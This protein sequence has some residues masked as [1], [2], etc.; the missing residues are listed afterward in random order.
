MATTPTL[1]NLPLEMRHHMYSYLLPMTANI[2]MVRDDMDGPL[3]HN[4]FRVCRNISSEAFNYYYSTNTFVLDLTEPTYAPNRFHSGTISLLKYIRPIQTLQLVI[5]DSC[6]LDTD[7][8]AL[9][10]YA[11]EQ[12]DWFLRTLQE[13]NKNDKGLWLKKLTVLDHCVT[14]AVEPIT[15]I[16][17]EMAQ[18]RRDVLAL[19]LEPFKSRIRHIKIESRALS[20]VRR[21]D[22]ASVTMIGR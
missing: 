14:S 1:L 5:G 21:L 17:V 9:S 15:P 8:C 16:I 2:N 19:L 22:V 7:P 13:A 12:F 20:Q 18:K 6:S 4:L 3:K 11:R 10:E